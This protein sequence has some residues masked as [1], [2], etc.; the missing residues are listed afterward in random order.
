M[1]RATGI[2]P[3]PIRIIRTGMTQRGKGRAAKAAT[4]TTPIVFQTGGD[5]VEEGLVASM[6]QPGG[7]ITGVSRMNVATDP[8]RRARSFACRMKRS[9]TGSSSRA[10][11]GDGHAVVRYPLTIFRQFDNQVCF[12]PEDVLPE[13]KRWSPNE[14]DGIGSFTP[15]PPWTGRGPRAR[16]SVSRKYLG[17]K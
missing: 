3:R 1:D 2:S 13:W 9:C 10:A 11:A 15:P 16:S 8:K 4:S 14:A 7:N 5:P 12:T 6:N 17:P